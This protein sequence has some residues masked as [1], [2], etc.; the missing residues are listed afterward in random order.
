MTPV[1]YLAVL[2]AAIVA[3]VLGGLWYGP[4]FGKKW[5]A[6]MGMTPEQIEAGKKKGMAKEYI[7][8]FIGSLVMA[9]V[10]AWG[11]FAG[12]PYL[13][14]EGTVGAVAGI[15]LGLLAWLGFVAPVTLGS[16]LWEGRSWT[17]WFLNNGYY[18]VTLA[19][20][21]AILAVWK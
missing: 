1:N 5:I 15:C 6:L 13:A 4:V 8:T 7:L 3:V 14:A 12:A 18:V 16:V 11:L 19:V 9:Y 2:V 21:G 17:L 10:L 20:I